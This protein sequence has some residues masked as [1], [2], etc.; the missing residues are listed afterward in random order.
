MTISPIKP[1][2]TPVPPPCPTSSPCLDSDLDV[3]N[4]MASVLDSGP[5][6]S[7]T[8][9]STPLFGEDD[10]T[11]ITFKTVLSETELRVQ[12]LGKSMIGEDL[13]EGDFE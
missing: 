7:R 4:L 13:G 10:P 8:P 2:E 11:P 12:A 9:F 1:T 6:P 5:T 3:L